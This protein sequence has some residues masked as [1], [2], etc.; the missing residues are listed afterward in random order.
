MSQPRTGR[1]QHKVIV[2]GVNYFYKVHSHG[3]VEPRSGMIP[4]A[5]VLT[6][7]AVAWVCL[8]VLAVV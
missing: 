1:F 5:E 6:A 4:F 2:D 8:A 7:E 3:G